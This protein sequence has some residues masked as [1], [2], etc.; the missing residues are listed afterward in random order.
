[1]PRLEDWQRDVHDSLRRE[2]WSLSGPNRIVKVL[3]RAGGSAT[4]LGGYIT[5]GSSLLG[6]TPQEIERARL[7]LNPIIWSAVL[8][9]TDL[10][11][12]P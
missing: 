8:G 7:D 6:K 3:P 12:F 2:N 10:L 4:V 11:A 1:M 9:S 5:T